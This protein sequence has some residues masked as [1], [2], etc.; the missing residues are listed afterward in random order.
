MRWRRSVCASSVDCVCMC[1]CVSLR[2]ESDLTPRTEACAKPRASAP[3]LSPLSNPELVLILGLAHNLQTKEAVIVW[4]SIHLLNRFSARN[5]PPRSPSESRELVL[6][7]DGMQCAL[8]SF[9]GLFPKTFPTHLRAAPRLVI[10]R[11]LPN[12]MPFLPLP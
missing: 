6:H 8:R 10:A 3:A 11:P 5:A 12:T 9:G 2:L 1:V 7:E 4:K